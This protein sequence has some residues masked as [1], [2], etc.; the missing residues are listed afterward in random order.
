M[1][2][3]FKFWLQ[4][5]LAIACWLKNVLPKHLMVIYSLVSLL[6]KLLVA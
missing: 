4:K 5:Y 6:E 1:T 3:F 2:L